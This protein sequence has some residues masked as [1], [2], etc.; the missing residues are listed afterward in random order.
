MKLLFFFEILLVSSGQLWGQKLHVPGDTIRCDSASYICESHVFSLAMTYRNMNFTDT[1]KVLYYDDGSKVPYYEEYIFIVE[2]WSEIE[3]WIKT[4]LFTPEEYDLV[5]GIRKSFRMCVYSDN[6]G[7][8][9][10]VVF[11]LF[12]NDPVFARIDANRLFELEKKLKVIMRL[13][14]PPKEKK[15]KN[16]T[17]R[18]PIQYSVWK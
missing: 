13:R 15:L 3:E 14:T 7:K 10:G 4:E 8:T 6:E 9:I 18:I 12:R 17:Y 16:F 11:E 1:T 5:K 2:G